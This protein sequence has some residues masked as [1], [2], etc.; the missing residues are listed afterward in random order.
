MKQLCPECVQN[1]GFGMSVSFSSC[2]C[3]NVERNSNSV[4]VNR[5]INNI[6]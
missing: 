2:D 3:S 6:Y 1:C 4:H 5:Y